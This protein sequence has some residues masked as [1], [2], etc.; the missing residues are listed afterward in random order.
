MIKADVEG[1]YVEEEGKA[2][3]KQSRKKILYRI[4]EDK[5]YLNEAKKY[6]MEEP[7]K[8]FKLFLKKI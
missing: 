2:K 6:I 1:F 3:N 4:N 8:Y 7:F 5:I